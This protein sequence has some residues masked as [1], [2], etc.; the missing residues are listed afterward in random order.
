[1]VELS[2]E[3]CRE[4]AAEFAAG[5]LMGRERVA[6]L[7]HLER[8]ARCRD[9]VDTFAATAARLVELLPEAEPPPGFVQRVLA[10]IAARR[11]ST[12]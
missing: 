2:C 7:A 10:V 8:C 11:S 4:V 5:A 1:M 9:T 6:I 12:T 3:Q